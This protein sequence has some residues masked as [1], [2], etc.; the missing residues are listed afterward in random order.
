MTDAVR[1]DLRDAVAYVTINRPDAMNAADAS[2]RDGLR[3]A[4]EQAADDADARAVLLTGEGRAFCVGQDLKEL[5]P[6]YESNDPDLGGIVSGFNELCLALTGLP[7]PTIAAV[8]GVAAGA[9]ASLAFACDFRVAS[10]KASFSMAFSKIGLVADTGSSWTLPRLVGG[11]K[12][13][14]MLMLSEPVSARDALGLGL[15]RQVVAPESLLDEAGAF[16]RQLAEGP[17]V[18]YGYIKRL[19]AAS[20]DSSLADALEVEA[21]LQAAAGRTEDH[22]NAVRSFLAKEQPTFRGY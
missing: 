3:A 22:L 20:F 1:Y 4:F 17:T 18:A 5:L 14:E 21:E 9:G 8:N 19:V 10:E 12:A 2:V 13:L 16:A 15:V 7:K 11:A 6:L